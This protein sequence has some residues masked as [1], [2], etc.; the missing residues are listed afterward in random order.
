[1]ASAWCDYLEAHARRVYHGLIQGDIST[2][3]RLGK[4]IAAGKLTNPFTAR[5]VYLKGW[6]GL[7]E[8]EVIE[9]GVTILGEMGWIK[10][11]RIAA[12]ANGGPAHFKVL[13]QPKGKGGLKS[14]HWLQSF[15]EEAERQNTTPKEPIKTYRTSRQP[16]NTDP[17]RPPKPTAGFDGFVGTG[18]LVYGRESDAR[19]VI[20]LPRRCEHCSKSKELKGA[21]AWRR[22]GRSLNGL[23]R[24]RGRASVS[25]LLASWRQ[26]KKAH[27]DT[28]KRQR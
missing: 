6:T 20:Q 22:H 18:T 25:S 10:I 3:H 23:G 1:M 21:P 13:D 4:K 26:F 16:E 17:S 11:E 12:G 7:S 9:A 19:K 8:P 24:R 28:S 2:A 5:E 27:Q 14:M 15:L